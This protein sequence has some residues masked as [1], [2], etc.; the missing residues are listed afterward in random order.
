MNR[1]TTQWDELPTLKT[2]DDDTYVYYEAESPGLSYFAISGK[3]EEVTTTVAPETTTTVAEVTTT[4]AEVTTTTVAQVVAPSAE[5]DF[6]VVLTI[7]IVLV[8]LAGLYYFI[9]RKKK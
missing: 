2:G 5:F 3:A 8:V 1:Y 9:L 6:R 7:V 4:T